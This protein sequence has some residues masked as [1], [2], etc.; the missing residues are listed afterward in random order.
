MPSEYSLLVFLAEGTKFLFVLAFGACVG[1]LMNVLVYRLPRGL[2]IVTPPSRCPVCDTKLTWRENIPIFGWIF[3]GG[4]CRFCKAKISPEYPLVEAFIAAM[5]GGIYALWYMLP[6][7]WGWVAWLRPEWAANGLLTTWPT[8]VIILTLASCLIAMTL[9]DAKTRM[10][11]LGL[12][13]FPALVALL[14]HPVH[15]AVL[16]FRGSE[17][18]RLAPGASWSIPTP[19]RHG[20]WWI[21]ASLGGALGLLLG[22][23]LIWSGLI[24]RSFLDYEEW[25]KAALAEQ[26]ASGK[27]APL[28]PDDPEAQAELWIAYP[29]ARREMIR[30]LAFL[31]PAVTLALVGGNLA[32][33][34]AGPWTFDPVRLVDIPASSAPLW[35]NVLAGVLM[36]YLI[37]GGVVWFARI[38]ATLAFGK[39]ALGLGDVHLM[40]GVGACLGWIDPILAFFAAAFIGVFAEAA[41]ALFAGRLRRTL[42]FGPCLALGTLLV[43]LMKPGAEWI[44]STLLHRTVDLP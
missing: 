18:I 36:G 24:R 7:E 16:E 23:V 11:P 43:V 29:H 13:W 39:E 8:F 21:G 9:I 31:A 42:A 12:L 19:G 17:W 38:A 10:I 2:D 35:L 4:R 15:A 1:S 33:R 6:S 32:A 26:A 30:E 34:L 37:A 22:N 25:E 41:R 14:I 28:S 3:L 44:L 27:S 40:A 5:F 20:W